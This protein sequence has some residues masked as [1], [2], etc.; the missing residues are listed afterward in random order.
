MTDARPQ[1]QPVAIT[2]RAYVPTAAYY[3]EFEPD[4]PIAQ[5]IRGW[6]EVVEKDFGPRKKTK[7]RGWRKHIRHM[8]AMSR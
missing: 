3:L 5:M 2:R 1:T 4:G 7:S 6:M 8:K